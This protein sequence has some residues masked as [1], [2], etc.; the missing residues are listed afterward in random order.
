[1]PLRTCA[2]CGAADNPLGRLRFTKSRFDGK[3]Y[4]EVDLPDTTMFSKS[5][6][7][8]EVASV[9]STLASPASAGSMVVV[10]CPDCAG[11]VHRPHHKP[12]VTCSGYG[13][14]RVQSNFLNV[15]RPPKPERITAPEILLEGEM[16]QQ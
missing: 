14:V 9:P 3:V 16:T 8:E 2:K 7:T 15:Y 13:S 10:N 11:G 1:M 12:C 6:G 4:C 5:A